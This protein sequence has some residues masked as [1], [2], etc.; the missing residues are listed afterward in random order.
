MEFITERKEKEKMP[1][2]GLETEI[3]AMVHSIRDMGEIV[4]VI[5][6]R[7]EGLFQAVYEK[8]WRKPWMKELRE[9]QA[10]RI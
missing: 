2:I 5:L 10:V 3:S 7:R 6:R 1:E 9:G 8:S 4:F